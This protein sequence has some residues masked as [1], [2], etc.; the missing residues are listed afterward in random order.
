MPAK[1]NTIFE[2]IKPI[3]YIV[4]AMVTLG[5]AIVTIDRYVAKEEDVKHLE[6][7]DQL[8]AERLDIAI[9]DDDIREAEHMVQRMEDW[10]KFEQKTAQPELTPMEQEALEAAKKRVG[11]LKKERADKKQAYDQRRLYRD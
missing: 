5:G 3:L 4:L 6:I 2:K 11:I 8:L 9:T 10:T 1:K 7:Q